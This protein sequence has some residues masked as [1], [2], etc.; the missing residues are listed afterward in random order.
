MSES[1]HQ[2]NAIVDQGASPMDLSVPTHSTQ[3]SAGQQMAVT[4]ATSPA[5]GQ[6]TISSTPTSVTS[7]QIRP[8]LISTAFGFLPNGSMTLPVPGSSSQP[9]ANQSPNIQVAR[10][11]IPILSPGIGSG[12][13]TFHTRVP[14]PAFPQQ[15]PM[16]TI[17][18]LTFQRMPTKGQSVAVQRLPTGTVVPIST[19][20]IL[21]V[22][23]AASPSK[24]SRQNHSHSKNNFSH[25]QKAHSSPSQN[26]LGHRIPSPNGQQ[27]TFQKALNPIV[28]QQMT[29]TPQPS[30]IQCLPNTALVTQ[31]L[32][33]NATGGGLNLQSTPSTVGNLQVSSPVGTTALVGS[34]TNIGTAT[35]L[36]GQY[37][38]P[39]PSVA[40]FITGAPTAITLT[41]TCIAPSPS[42]NS[43]QIL[44]LATNQQGQILRPVSG[45]SQAQ[46]LRAGIPVVLP[47]AGRQQV[48]KSALAPRLIQKPLVSPTIN[49]GRQI[50]MQMP[51]LIRSSSSMNPVVGPLAENIQANSPMSGQSIAGLGV[52]IVLTTTVSSPTTSVT[53]SVSAPISSVATAVSQ[54][55]DHVGDDLRKSPAASSVSALSTDLKVVKPAENKSTA[56][57]AVN[58]DSAETQRE[59]YVNSMGDAGSENSQVSIVSNG[60]L[61]EDPATTTLP[62]VMT[63]GHEETNSKNNIGADSNEEDKTNPLTNSEMSSGNQGAILTEGF[64]DSNLLEWADGV[65]RLPGTDMKFKIN[66]FGDL[67][68][69]EDSTT[70]SAAK[71]DNVT[72]INMENNNES[73]VDLADGIDNIDGK[74][75]SVTDPA[76]LSEHEGDP[77][78]CCVYCGRYGYKS[79]FRTSGRFCSQTCAGK[80]NLHRKQMIM[81]RMMMGMKNKKKKL[82]PSSDV[83]IV[84]KEDVEVIEK[85]TD[86]KVLS[87]DWDKYLAETNSVA[88]P[89]R[90]FK[91]P[92]PSNRNGFRLCMR[93]EGVDPKHQSLFCVLSVAE[94]QGYRMRLHFDGYSECYD[95]WVNADSP[96]IFPV[97]WAEKNGKI[98][99]PPKNMTAEQFNWT[100]YLKQTRAVAAPKS[101]FLNQPSSVTPS[102]FRVGM[103][104]EAVDKKNSSLVCVATVADTLGDR[105][106]IHFDGWED[107][108]DYWCDITSPSIHPVG[109]CKANGH[110]LSPPPDYGDGANFT[111]DTYLA[112][113]KTTAVP[114]R[115]FKT[116]VAM[117]FEKG[118]KV[119]VV[120][121]RNPILI[122]VATVVD[123]QD[124][125]LLIHF[126][127]WDSIYDY[128]IDDD[129]SDL[130]PPQWCSKTFHPLQSPIDKKNIKTNVDSGGC[131]T[132]GCKGIGHIKGAKYTG[133]HSAFG[134]PYSELNMSKDTALTDRLGS[135][136]SEEGVGLQSRTDINADMRKCPTPGC[137]G[138]GHVT[139]K[140]TSHHC[141][142]GCPL[143]EKNM[144]KVK[145]E[146]V[147]EPRP[148]GRPGRGRKRKMYST[149]TP[150]L[151]LDKMIKTEPMEGYNDEKNSLHASIHE[152]V[153]QT[154]ALSP[155]PNDQ[156]LCWEQHAKLL[157]G[158]MEV[159]QSLVCNWSVDEVADF[160]FKLTGQQ[161]QAQKFK[162]EEVDGDSFLLL[163][164]SDLLN[165]LNI[166][167]GPAIKIFNSILVFKAA[168][169][170]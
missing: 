113:T 58:A 169:D 119:E 22:Q 125:R 117:G 126:D 135:S 121:K 159:N 88:A 94:I 136:R 96:F 102:A 70:T 66:E 92:F 155:P 8:Q 48:P 64:I 74:V 27:I 6:I 45:I 100:S 153:F 59:S 10:G 39:R 23:K 163:Q 72:D 26:H 105:I 137:D 86:K 5:V 78:C 62:E 30:Y 170:F 46:A 14:H 42:T 37:I 80:K 154:S 148:V 91:E 114:S 158:I 1:D 76:E 122:R 63:N 49:T 109:W 83:K 29:G 40:T 60:V 107:V 38:Q 110:S 133:H 120:D 33:Q 82:I 123:V 103:K 139:G 43:S 112:D 164:Q 89:K 111:W 98:L 115:A 147:L 7:F 165:F 57:S 36:A 95:F 81:S 25:T 55:P 2:D 34:P 32:S 130:H 138:L 106:L 31:Q 18:Q 128:W 124:Y 41:V 127:G 77:V 142:S 134:C 129:S 71:S 157:P 87:F 85:T 65:G 35:I 20:Q 108:Y 116:R 132:I 90:L 118:M 47:R 149:S 75:C 143:A 160:V 12:Q 99:Q 141:L 13:L 56:L 101:L 166:K 9:M 156:P 146:T 161:D 15:I 67:E 145:Q 4:L 167:L 93:L 54:L 68:L 21:N 131:P 84:N 162:D 150:L 61:N 152:S 73:D 11:G 168:N 144:V 151:P 69:V 24:A 19:Q 104:L 3:P 140:F 97:G 16:S 53:T 52:A 50:A 17:Q 51:S 44:S 79:N 28:A